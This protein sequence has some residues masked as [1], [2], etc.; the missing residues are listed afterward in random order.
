LKE[1]FPSLTGFRAI[2]AWM[3]F[4]HHYNPLPRT[5]FISDVTNEGYTGV[6]LFFV[7]S[8]SRSLFMIQ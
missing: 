5:L 8:S 2:A 6:T 4:A 1:Y 3:V 7:L